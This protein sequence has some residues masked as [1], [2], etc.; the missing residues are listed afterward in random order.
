MIA[1]WVIFR[2]MVVD[3]D[4]ISSIDDIHIG[5]LEMS[6]HAEDGFDMN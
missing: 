5:H 2:S 1:A 4:Y 6:F 3:D